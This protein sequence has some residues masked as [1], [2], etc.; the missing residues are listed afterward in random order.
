MVANFVKEV[1]SDNAAVKLVDVI[2]HPQSTT[3]TVDDAKRSAAS[4]DQVPL[5]INTFVNPIGISTLKLLC[6]MYLIYFSDINKMFPGL[7]NRSGP[8]DEGLKPL[9]DKNKKTFVGIMQTSDVLG[10]PDAKNM[11]NVNVFSNGG[12]LQPGCYSD[13]NNI[14]QLGYALKC[15]YDR[16]LELLRNSY[17]KD[18]KSRLTVFGFF[19]ECILN[20]VF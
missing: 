9:L 5:L 16:G 17:E 14:N 2:N 4:D 20:V 19:V 12:R 3:E 6:Q 8:G 1:E 11:A 7:I 13:Q 15:S 10:N 18:Y